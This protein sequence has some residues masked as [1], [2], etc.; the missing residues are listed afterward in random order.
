MSL[1]PRDMLAARLDR[2][3]QAIR[4]TGLDA[5]AVTHLPNIF[6]LSNFAGSA[7]MVVVAGPRLYLLADFRYSAAVADLT[8]A[9]RTPPGFALVDVPGSYDEALA[10]LLADV[11]AGRRVGFEAA[12]VPV[13]QHAWLTARLG[14][15]G[16]SAPHLVAA[17][18]LVE[19]MRLVKDGHELGLLRE[20]GRLISEV[21]RGV[22]RQVARPGRRER[23][24]AADID[25]RMRRAGFERA[26]FETIVA[27]GPNAALP[28][29]RPGDRVLSEGDLVVL[30]FGGVRGGY[31]VDLTR[32]VALGSPSPEAVRIYRAVAA[33]Q[34]AAL[35]SVRPG[36]TADRVDAAARETL[37]AA[38][39]GEAF[40]HSTG[41]GL[42]LEVHE[43]PRVGRLRPEGPPPTVLEAGMV[44][45][46][47]PGAYV[48]GFGGVRLED[49]VVVTAA[50]AELLT[51]VPREAQ[52]L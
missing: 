12:H 52:L 9:G 23:E 5:L 38:G 42:G 35:G 16:E 19:R 49:D 21:A 15:A 40:G 36:I 13:K 8:S 32:T 31:C 27:S 17:E 50:G 41:H 33:A 10:A 26:A 6:Y 3:R 14:A 4:E 1:A 46:I 11:L 25:H 37:A 28:H 45:T 51:D 30:D 18:G 39:L 24:V 7:G 48:P 29:A 43:D 34:D 20:G 44:C 47:E 22:L 2:L